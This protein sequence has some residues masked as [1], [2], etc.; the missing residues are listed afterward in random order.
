[1]DSAGSTDPCVA[2]PAFAHCRDRRGSAVLIVALMA[3]V[4]AARPAA[5][6]RPLG[7]AVTQWNAVATEAFTPSQGTNPV[8]Q[9]RTLAILHAAIHDA[10]NAIDRRFEVYTPG[11]AAAPGASV[12]AAVSAAARDIL[13]TLLP[14]EA[15]LVEAAYGRALAAIPDGP[16]KVA[17]IATGRRPRRRI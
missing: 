10:L 6:D 15:A 4:A 9:S 8:A 16:A 17:G 5:S 12:E 1:M 2:P 7:N 14:D 11:L 13:V 3:V